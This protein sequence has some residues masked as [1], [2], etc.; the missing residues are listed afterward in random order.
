MHM[1]YIYTD[2]EIRTMCTV[3][4]SYMKYTPVALYNHKHTPS[5]SSIQLPLSPLE[6]PLQLFESLQVLLHLQSKGLGRTTKPP[7]NV[8][9]SNV[10]GMDAKN[11]K[12]V[13]SFM[14]MCS[15]GVGFQFVF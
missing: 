15:L 5:R 7:R 9:T 4:D 3:Y 13:C 14:V 8:H 1:L 12:T 11:V 6:I 10:H 2:G